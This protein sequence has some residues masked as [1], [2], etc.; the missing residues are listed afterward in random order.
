MHRFEGA[1]RSA[2]RLGLLAALLVLFLCLCSTGFARDCGDGI[3][4]ATEQCDDDNLF[5][6]DGCAANCT[7]ETLREFVIDPN[8]S[9]AIT[10]FARQALDLHLSGRLGFTTGA[11]DERG[12]IPLVVRATDLHFDP[13]VVPSLA[14]VCVRAFELPEVFGFGPGNVAGG[15]IGC[16]EHG[17]FR[18]EFIVTQDHDIG[19]VGHCQG[20]SNNGL[21]C[22][23]DVNC[24]DGSCFTADDCAAA[25]GIVE[26]PGDPH[27][28]VCNGPAVV[29]IDGE[30]SPRGTA[31][32]VDGISFALLFDGGTCCIAG[33]DPGCEDPEGLKGPDGIACTEDDPAVGQPSNVPATT[34]HGRI[35]VFN[36]DNVPGLTIGPGEMCG[37]QPCIGEF[38][39]EPFDCD[40]MLANPTGGMESGLFGLGLM[41][42]HNQQFGDSVSA[43]KL[44]A[45]PAC[46]GDCN[47]NDVVTIDE[48]V[49]AV[50]RALGTKPPESCGAIDR[51]NDG[52]V[53]VNE[54]IAAV[55]SALFGCG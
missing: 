54:L 15:T 9:T 36:A 48:L 23:A 40:A 37:E 14:C 17:L 16:G 24:V 22:P 12:V 52:E 3:L 8:Q 39:G 10:Q 41:I 51:D 1:Q 13:I 47:R 21:A 7:R 50:G 4:D 46:P 28:G 38:T 11:V 25:Q 43:V 29:G 35:F 18:N 20:G 30:G 55:N 42:L 2:N 33:V 31:A 27:P 19:V 32:I 44:A 6:G 49:T 34:T 5:G 53:Q 26:G 45:A